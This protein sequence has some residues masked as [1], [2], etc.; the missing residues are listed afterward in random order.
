MSTSRIRMG[1]EPG[2][3]APNTWNDFSWARLHHEELL[4]K[5]GT[6]VALIY[7]QRVIGTG[8]TYDEAL[9]DAEQ[10]LPAAAH[11]I[12]PI[13]YLINHRHRLYRVRTNK[14]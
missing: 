4:E 13:V 8:V 3:V 2:E 5:Y 6:C 10:H 1:H 11:D 12:T 14:G 9:A 7:Q